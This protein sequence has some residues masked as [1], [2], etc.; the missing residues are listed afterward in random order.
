MR[1]KNALSVVVALF[2]GFSVFG[3]GF[4]LYEPSAVSHAMG[5]ALVGKA[6]D[7]SANF[8]NPAT[9]SDLT[10]IN[11]TVGFVTEHPRCKVRVN[12]GPAEKLDPGLF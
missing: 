4:A 8:N 2:A 11:L 1:L 12:D 7:A 6:M 10:N 3:S 5:G 9:L